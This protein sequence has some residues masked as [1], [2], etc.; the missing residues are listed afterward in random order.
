MPGRGLVDGE[1]LGLFPIT[2]G[3][4]PTGRNMKTRTE[5]IIVGPPIDDDFNL[6]PGLTFRASLEPRRR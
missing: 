4:A 3:I 1:E 6:E 2:C 5:D